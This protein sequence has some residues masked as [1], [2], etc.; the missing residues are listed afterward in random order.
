MLQ[1]L[2]YTITRLLWQVLFVNL[3]FLQQPRFVMSM[4]IPGNFAHFSLFLVSG[5]VD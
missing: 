5:D 4:P 3:I 1:K 2:Y